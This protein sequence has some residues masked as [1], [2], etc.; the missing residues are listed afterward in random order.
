MTRQGHGKY[1][2]GYVCSQLR[3]R[4]P[5][6]GRLSSLR[7]S[8]IFNFCLGYTHQFAVSAFLLASYPLANWDLERV[9]F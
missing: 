6:I 4:Q 9:G 5:Q 3:R 2:P 1:H 8:P 7:N